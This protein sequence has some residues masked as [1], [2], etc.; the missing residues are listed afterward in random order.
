MA[1]T[2][3]IDIDI[4][5]TEQ[6]YNT[7]AMLAVENKYPFQ[8]DNSHELLNK[9]CFRICQTSPM[10]WNLESV[11]QRTFG[12]NI[13]HDSEHQLLLKPSSNNLD[14]QGKTKWILAAF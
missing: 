5:Q 11:V 2:I 4:F 10:L 13:L 3:S 7:I 8:T 14:G 9:H 1:D 12:L 6:P